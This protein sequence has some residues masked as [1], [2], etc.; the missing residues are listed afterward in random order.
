MK[1]DLVIFDGSNF[2]HGAKRISP[3]THLTRFDYRKLAEAV[4]KNKN[5]KIEYCVGEIRRRKRDPKSFRLYSNQQLLFINLEKQGI[6]VKKGFMLKSDGV[7]REKGVDVRI[8]LDILRG[9]L[10]DEYRR[11]FIISSDTDLVPAILDSRTTKKEIIYVGF[12][13]K[14]SNALHAV[15]SRT[16]LLA[17]KQIATCAPKH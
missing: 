16:I 17:R 14:L 2:Y 10:K 12:E 4:C 9:A 11:C 7:Y 1:P 13:G 3:Q 5:L 8:A 6:L 15:C